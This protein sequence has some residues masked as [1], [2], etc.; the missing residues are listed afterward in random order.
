MPCRMAR[1]GS[2]GVDGT[3]VIAMAPVSSPRHTKSENVPPVSTV[4]RYIPNVS[5]LI[6]A[7]TDVFGAVL[8]SP[9]RRLGPI[10]ER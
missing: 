2:S 9:P 6:T 5:S 10:A 4:I 8:S 7:Q 1:D 3:F